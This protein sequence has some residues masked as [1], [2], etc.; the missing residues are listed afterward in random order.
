MITFIV[1]IAACSKQTE[2]EQAKPKK[3]NHTSKKVN[4]HDLAASSTAASNSTTAATVSDTVNPATSSATSSATIPTQ[5]ST[6]PA[7][8]TTPGS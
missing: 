6:T 3:V 1:A 8:S 7:V 2:T 5:T 4:A